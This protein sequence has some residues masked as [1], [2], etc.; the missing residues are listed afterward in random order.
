MGAVSETQRSDAEDTF[1][2]GLLGKLDTDVQASRAKGRTVAV[3]WGLTKVKTVNNALK[4]RLYGVLIVECNQQAFLQDSKAYGRPGN[5]H[6]AS[7]ITVI[8]GVR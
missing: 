2:E 4:V 3:K 7:R 5:K 6:V 8:A 1:F